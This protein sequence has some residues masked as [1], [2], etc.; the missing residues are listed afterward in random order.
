MTYRIKREEMLLK[1]DRL[2]C[3]KCG[4]YSKEPKG[5]PPGQDVETEC[6]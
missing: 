5:I 3:P 4:R 1:K 6:S 2:R